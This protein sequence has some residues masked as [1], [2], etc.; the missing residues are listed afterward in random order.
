MELVGAVEMLDA[1]LRRES[2]KSLSRFSTAQVQDRLNEIAW[3]DGDARLRKEAIDGL[4]RQDDVRANRL[5]LEIARKLPN[6][7][8]S[9]AALHR[10]QRE[11]F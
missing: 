3:S 8:T 1:G 7:Q 4:A 9:A 2:V 5:L 10:F 6:R 11:L